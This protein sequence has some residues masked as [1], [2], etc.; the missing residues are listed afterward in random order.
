[1]VADLLPLRVRQF[2]GLVEDL[3]VH[4]ELADVVQESRPAEPVSIA[5]G[6]PHLVGDHVGER[7]D[8]FGVPACLSIVAAQRGC[9]RQ[10]LLG[11]GRRHLLVRNRPYA[12]AA[13]EL[14]GRTRSPGDLQPFGRLIGE[15]HAHLQ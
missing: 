8:P 2:L 10:D 13:F 6:K 11:H 4:G 15:K 3:R 1:V 9:Q 12:R 7:P 5:L 14:A